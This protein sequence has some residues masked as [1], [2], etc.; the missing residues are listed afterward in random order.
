MSALPLLSEL[1]GRGVHIRVD[2]HNL[3]VSQDKMTG[4]LDTRIRENKPAL[5]ASLKQL[6][7]YADGDD[8]DWQEVVSHPDQLRAFIYSIVTSEARERGEIPPSYTATVHC[9][10]CNQDVPHFPIDSDTVETCVWCMGGQA[11]PPLSTAIK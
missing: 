6:R 3:V 9:Q 8:D 2:G 5:I 4:S 10:T 11:P 7:Q 1:A